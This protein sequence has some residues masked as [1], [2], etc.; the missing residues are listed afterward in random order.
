MDIDITA[1]INLII[2]DDLMNLIN[3]CCYNQY[4]MMLHLWLLLF[5]LLILIILF[6]SLLHTRHVLHNSFAKEH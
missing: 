4:N 5:K 6:Q 3:P 1:M 2:F